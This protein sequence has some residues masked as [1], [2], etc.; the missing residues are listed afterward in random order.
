M[1]GTMMR[2]FIQELKSELVIYTQVPLGPKSAQVL[3]V[4]GREHAL[5]GPLIW[6]LRGSLSA[7]PHF[8][9]AIFFGHRNIF[10]SEATSTCMIIVLGDIF[11]AT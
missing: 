1:V 11:L 6:T 10:Q 3:V 2:S 8:F 9:S 4:R 7:E 5:P